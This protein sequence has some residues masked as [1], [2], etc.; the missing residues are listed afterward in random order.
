MSKIVVDFPN[1][2]LSNFVVQQNEANSSN[3]FY[4]PCIILLN[5]FILMKE[6]FDKWGWIMNHYKVT[7]KCIL[8]WLKIF[9]KH[10]CI[11]GTSKQDNL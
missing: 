1:F 11:D 6:Y 4:T 8:F 9:V 5:V 2:I 3:F 10:L 7:E